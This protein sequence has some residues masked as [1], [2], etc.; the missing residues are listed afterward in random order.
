MRRPATSP[1]RPRLRPWI[2]AAPVLFSYPTIDGGTLSTNETAGRF[3]VLGFVATYDDRSHAQARFLSVLFRRHVPR[4]NAGLVVLEPEAN[5]LFIE[6]FAKVLEPPYPVA[7]ADEATIAGAGPFR[8]LHHVPS[9]VI[10]DPEGREAFRHLGLIDK[11]AL[12]AVLQTL[13]KAR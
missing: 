2:A 10:L 3:T 7:I 13:E 12:D 1:R 4:I 9:V 8:E 6:T 11:N 5:R